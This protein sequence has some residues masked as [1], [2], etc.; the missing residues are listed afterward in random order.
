MT[1]VDEE[2]EEDNSNR[3][4]KVV[5]FVPH[6]S[7]AC[8]QQ[9]HGDAGGISSK[10]TAQ[11][12]PPV[13]LAATVNDEQIA[14]GCVYPHLRDIRQVSARVGAAVAEANYDR[15][16][17]ADPA[18]RPADFMALCESFQYQPMEA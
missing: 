2:H 16:T 10:T 13:G 4:E 15:G 3:D 7:Q 12:L 18:A 1:T 8:Q 9:Q 11:Q 5:S 17:V 6:Q 14:L